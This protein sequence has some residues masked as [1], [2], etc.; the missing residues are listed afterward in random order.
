MYDKLNFAG[1]HSEKKKDTKE[2]LLEF[3]KKRKGGQLSRTPKYQI[4]LATAVIRHESSVKTELL[5]PSQ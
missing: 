1:A 4:A 3:T 2:Y 5:L